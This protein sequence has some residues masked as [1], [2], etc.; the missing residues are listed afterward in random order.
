MRRMPQRRREVS[1]GHLGLGKPAALMLLLTVLTSCNY[2]RQDQPLFEKIAPRA[3][4]IFFENRLT[5]EPLFNS[6]NYLYFYD[7]GGVA[8]GDINND[9]LADIYFTANMQS[10]RLYLNKGDFRFE[11]ITTLAGVAGGTAGWSTGVTMADVNG[12]GL[13][14]IYVS[15]SNFLDKRG[16]NQ[17]FINNGD[18]TF[19]ESAK[20]YGL[21]FF[22]LSR[23]AA[24]FD[25]DLDGALDMYQ[26]NHSMPKKLTGIRACAASGIPRPGISFSSMSRATF[27]IDPPR[28]EF[29]RAF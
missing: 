15:R 18:L 23:Q 28:W 29:G 10:N 26:L 6:I 3:S 11:D 8:V 25:F 5:E 21:D 13:L 14:D 19:T 1:A 16:A 22:G 4:G 20:E 17:L 12:D 7:G 24:F 9:G 27:Q 2:L